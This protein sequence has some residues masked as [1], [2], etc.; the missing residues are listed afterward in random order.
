MDQMRLQTVVRMCKA[1]KPTLSLEFAIQELGF[2]SS[3]EGESFLCRAGC[4]IVN[5]TSE[6]GGSELVINTKDSVINSAAVF[7]QDKLLL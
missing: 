6:T 7:T 5:G 3:E 2:D 1:Y 4:I